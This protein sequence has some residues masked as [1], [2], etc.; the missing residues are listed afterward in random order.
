M[1]QLNSE[2]QSLYPYEYRF[3]SMQT[4]LPPQ[5]E[6]FQHELL[7]QFNSESLIRLLNIFSCTK[8]YKKYI[9]FFK[10]PYEMQVK[11]CN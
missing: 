1:L 2:S 5:N 9:S 8:L 3:L 11:I 4:E 7:L 6:G 10:L